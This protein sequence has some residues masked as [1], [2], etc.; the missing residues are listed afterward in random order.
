MSSP[1]GMRVTALLLAWLAGC[2]G[3]AAQPTL[4]LQLSLITRASATPQVR[5]RR[6]DLALS[7]SVAMPLDPASSEGARAPPLAAASWR[8]PVPEQPDCELSSDPLCSWGQRA[9]QLALEQ[10]PTWLE[11]PQ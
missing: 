4:L 9:E 10:A 3:R 11:S 6:H 1:F 5:Q 7:A 2:S 8:S